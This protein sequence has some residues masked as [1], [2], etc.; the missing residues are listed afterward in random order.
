MI[1]SVHRSRGVDG[2]RKKNCCR[3]L[4]LEGGQT[5]GIVCEVKKIDQKHICTKKIMQ[6]L[7]ISS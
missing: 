3:N 4:F 2:I 1:W 5:E 6:I 7:K